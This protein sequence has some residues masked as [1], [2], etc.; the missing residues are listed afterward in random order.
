MIVEL[1]SSI[2]LAT[3]VSGCVVPTVSY[4]QESSNIYTPNI[5]ESRNNQNVDDNE[6]GAISLSPNNFSELDSYQFSFSSELYGRSGN[7]DYDYYYISVLSKSVFTFSVKNDGEL[8]FTFSVYTYIN[9]S[10]NN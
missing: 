7:T 2:V 8:P 5:T 10:Q 9:N 3:N 4:L 6:Y 1:L